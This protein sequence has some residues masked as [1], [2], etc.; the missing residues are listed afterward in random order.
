MLIFHL[1]LFIILAVSLFDNS[2]LTRSSKEIV[3]YVLMAVLI[4]F[5]GLRAPG[6]DR[7]YKNYQY[8]Y[9]TIPGIQ[10]LT[11]N[12]ETYFNAI[13]IEPTFMLLAS[14][15]KLF[16][17]NGLPVLIFV[18]ALI[19]ISLKTVSIL[20]ISDYPLLTILLYFSTIFL[21]QDM[22]Q[23]R[24]G[25]ALSFAFLSIIALNERKL[26]KYVVFIIV[27]I[28][29]HYSVIFFAPFYFLNSKKINKPLYLSFIVI[30]ILLYFIRFNP[31]EILQSFDFGLYSTKLNNYVKMQS[32]LKE[33]INMFN[34]SIIIQI[35]FAFIFIYYA[36]KSE[37]KFTI[38][39]TKIFCIG[40]GVF[41]IFSF[42][43]VIAFRSSELL[44]SVQIFLL[45]T[46]ITSFKHKALGEFIIIV[47]ALLHFI[48]LIIVNT[49]FNPYH[50]LFS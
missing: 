18:Y 3:V 10:Y 30:P 34:F 5:A 49:I 39:L 31:L 16:I 42:S 26:I 15:T 19:S 47:F 22:T 27:G 41:F 4:I 36:D 38:I 8:L 40:I 1:I 7:D 23:I 43:P 6:I 46:I 45:P 12:P 2:K 33:D 48:N 44:T 14:I 25:I 35:I 29:F 11:L 9:S 21:L 17:Y 24:V 32:W 37:N 13:S 28:F 50:T 20:R